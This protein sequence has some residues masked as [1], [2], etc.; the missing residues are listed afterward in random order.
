MPKCKNCGHDLTI[1]DKDLCPFCGQP[2]PFGDGAETQ[3]VTQFVDNVEDISGKKIYKRKKLQIYLI[4]LGSCGVFAAHLFYIDKIKQAIF[5]LFS[6][7]LFIGGGGYLLTYLF[8]L[9]DGLFYLYWIISFGIL[10][11]IYIVLSIVA[12]CTGIV[13]DNEGQILK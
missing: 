11:L 8:K 13:T 5:L 2:H 1:N 3:D 4:L 6:N 7:C 10:F 9:P 12:K